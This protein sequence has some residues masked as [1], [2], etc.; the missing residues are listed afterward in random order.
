[1]KK[2]KY[3]TC[4]VLV[5]LIMLFACIPK[6]SAYSEYVSLNNVDTILYQTEHSITMSEVVDIDRAFNFGNLTLDYTYRRVNDEYYLYIYR[7]EYFANGVFI[8]DTLDESIELSSEVFNLIG[9]ESEDRDYIEYLYNVFDTN[10]LFVTI[11]LEDDLGYIYPT[12]NIHDKNFY[13]VEYEFE[14]EPFL[15]QGDYV[16]YT[17]L[18]DFE[19]EFIHT[20]ML[21]ETYLYNRYRLDGNSLAQIG[22]VSITDWLINSVGGLFDTPILGG[23]SIGDILMFILAIGLLFLFL[24][25]FAGG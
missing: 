10:I 9:D 18:Y 4:A 5:C 21:Y 3:I 24:R 22:E 14:L 17:Y 7:Y 2:I 19:L 6:A 20:T 13:F 12:I 1:M 25:F 11:T 8:N 15:N 23:V 16:S